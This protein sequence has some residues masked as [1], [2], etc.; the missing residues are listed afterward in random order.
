MDQLAQEPQEPQET[1]TTAL[2]Q[3]LALVE[4][5]K[6]DMP[7]FEEDLKTSTSA[8]DDLAIAGLTK[9]HKELE[10]T[11]ANFQMSSGASLSIYTMMLC[12]NSDSF[13]RKQE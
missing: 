8:F 2:G 6:I 10:D 9:R 13:I 7:D 1:D 11:L 5:L 4:E 3:L 12:L